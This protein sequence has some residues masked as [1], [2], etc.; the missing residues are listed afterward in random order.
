MRALVLLMVLVLVGCGVTARGWVNKARVATQGVD[1]VA[2]EQIGKK[3]MAAAQACGKTTPAA[4]CAAWVSC[5]AARTKYRA[6]LD[7]IDGSLSVL[8]LVL[9]DLGVK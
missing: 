4:R 8:N 9:S 3:C 2:L 5:D 7:A 1:R 6:A